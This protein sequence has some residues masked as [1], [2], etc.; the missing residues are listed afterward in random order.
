MQDLDISALVERLSSP[1]WSIDF[2]PGLGDDEVREAEAHFGFSFPPDLLALLQYA[3]PVGDVAA[4]SDS[5][6]IGG[7]FP[8]WRVLNSRELQSQVAWPTKSVIVDVRESGFWLEM[9]GARPPDVNEA[10]AIASL[11]LG[12]A[13]KL[14]PVYAHR[15]ICEEPHARGNPIISVWGTDIVYYGSDL[16]TYIANEFFLKRDD[17]DFAKV[18]ADVP[19]WL[20]IMTQAWKA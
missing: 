9:W 13:P 20:S 1:P 11:S 5:K 12:A 19:F 14:I 4:S 17:R 7:G 15:Y 8:N 18:P 16:A 3:M 10:A 2:H 6:N